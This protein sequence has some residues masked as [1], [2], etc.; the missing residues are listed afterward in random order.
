MKILITSAGSLV[1]QNILDALEG[2]RDGVFIIGSNSTAEAAN[3][4]RCDLA[5][6]APPAADAADWCHFTAEL[7]AN[8]GV[9]LVLPARDDD[10]RL[11]ARL[12]DRHPQLRRVI[13]CGSETVAAIL[14]DKGRSRDFAL[15]HQLPFAAS[16]RGAAEIEALLAEAGFPLIAKPLAGNGSRGVRVIRDAQELTQALAWP[17]YL[18]QEY[19]GPDRDQ[20]DGTD[21]RRA[22]VPLFHAPPYV[23]LAAQALISPG[24]TVEAVFCG[25]ITMVMGRAERSVALDAPDFAAIAR[26]YAEAFAAAGWV[27]LINIQG[28]R[29]AKGQF[30][31]YEFNGRVAGASAT[32]LYLDFDEIAMLA[33]HFAGHT[34]APHPRG[35]ASNRIVHKS[36]SD[37]LIEAEEL[38]TLAR[39]GR[40]R[41]SP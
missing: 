28:R 26:S 12:R 36:L 25:E 41:K 23:H 29:N 27:G 3:L 20:F 40:W 19:L 22:G 16:A 39:E 2:R 24:G 1:G 14:E 30:K 32:R 21:L 15:T 7:I 31:A 9:D 11:L 37:Y 6:L 13:A 5:L 33:E 34:L 38:A 8:E 10:V 17:D 18:F 35:G 4:F